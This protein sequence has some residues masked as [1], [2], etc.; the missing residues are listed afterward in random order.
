MVNRLHNQVISWNRSPK[1]AVQRLEGQL[2]GGRP[3]AST[4]AKGGK[5]VVLNSVPRQTNT[6]NLGTIFLI[7]LPI[8]KTHIDAS[9]E[10]QQHIYIKNLIR[11]DELSCSKVV[12][13]SNN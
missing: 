9:Y 11:L 10:K 8:D 13:P 2:K 12:C 6:F 5:E 7:E 1:Y 3:S 4:R